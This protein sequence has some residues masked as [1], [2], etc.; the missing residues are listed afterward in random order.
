MLALGIEAMSYG[1]GLSLSRPPSVSAYGRRSASWYS[2]SDVLC[3]VR[4]SY[5]DMNRTLRRR[6]MRSRMSTQGTMSAATTRTGTRITTSAFVL[7]A[8][9]DAAPAPGVAI[10][11]VEKAGVVFAAP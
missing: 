8:E 2:M 6:R 5:V 10:L 9:F 11:L 1:N 3:P 7:C 4:S